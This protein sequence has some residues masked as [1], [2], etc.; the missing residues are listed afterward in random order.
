MLSS[1]GHGTALLPGCP[2]GPAP[3]PWLHCL[4]WVDG[5]VV[6]SLCASQMPQTFLFPL[7]VPA[8]LSFPHSLLLAASALNLRKPSTVDRLTT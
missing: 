7:Q 6:A 5:V 1:G 8:T 4:P 2:P 3:C